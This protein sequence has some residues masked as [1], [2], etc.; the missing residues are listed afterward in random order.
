MS[1]LFERLK[2]AKEKNKKLLENWKLRE[3]AENLGFFQK[4]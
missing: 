1:I 2:E 3:E 4:K